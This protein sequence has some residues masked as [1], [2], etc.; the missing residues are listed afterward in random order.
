MRPTH[1]PELRQDM[2]EAYSSPA[3]QQSWMRTNMHAG[4]LAQSTTEA[5]CADALRNEV[6]RWSMADLYFVTSEMTSLALEAAKSIPTFSLLPSDLPSPHGVMYFEHG[7]GSSTNK[8]YGVMETP[9]VA[10]SWG[11]VTLGGTNTA[12]A[13][14]ERRHVWVSFFTDARAVAWQMAQAKVP[15]GKRAKYLSEVTQLGPLSYDNE[16]LL[17]F[18]TNPELTPPDVSEFSGDSL[19]GSSLLVLTAWLLMQ[20]P[21]ACVAEEVPDRQTRRR[22]ERRGVSDLEPVRVITLRHQRSASSGD[23]SREFHHRWMVKGHWR[24]QWY[25]SQERHVPIWISPHIK[26]P[27][28]APILGGEKVYSWSR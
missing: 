27:E 26:G 6:Q 8:D 21:I 17:P 9:Y 7:V 24:N 28:G 14:E 12:G 5:E 2:L 13:Y 1:L 10:V 19:R 4:F 16:V 18:T 20:Q 25:A 15:Q 11:P 3:G 22:M 23:G